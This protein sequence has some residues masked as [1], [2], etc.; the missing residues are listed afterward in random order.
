MTK[1]LYKMNTIINK[2]HIQV[3]P[4]N[5][6]REIFMNGGTTPSLMLWN[7]RKFSWEFIN[8]D[9]PEELKKI[10]HEISGFII[11]AEKKKME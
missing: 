2:I 8:A 9:T 7:K 11:N 10:E 5:G 6:Q 1:H 4:K 3:V